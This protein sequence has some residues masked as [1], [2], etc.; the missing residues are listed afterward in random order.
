[1]SQTQPQSGS[2]KIEKEWWSYLDLS[3]RSGIPV[4]TL[5]K[6][7]YWG[8]LRIKREFTRW[9]GYQIKFYPREAMDRLHYLGANPDVLRQAKKIVADRLRE[10]REAKNE[11]QSEPG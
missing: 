1:M 5:Q 7:V 2:L 6:Y 9:G 8:V 4:S 3:A 10:K 11:E